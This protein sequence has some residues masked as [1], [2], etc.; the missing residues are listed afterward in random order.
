MLDDKK[1][2]E[3]FQAWLATVQPPPKENPLEELL[4]ETPADE[5]TD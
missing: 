4:E 5:E 2:R 3:S 1:F